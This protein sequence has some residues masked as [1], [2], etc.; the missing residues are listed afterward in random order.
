MFEG[1]R[2]HAAAIFMIVPLV[3]LSAVLVAISIPAWRAARVHPMEA[4]RYE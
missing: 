2:V 1:W 4:L 3:L